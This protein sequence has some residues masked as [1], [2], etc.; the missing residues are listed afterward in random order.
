MMG[1][2][3]WA[4]LAM[5]AASRWIRPGLIEILFLL[6]PWVVVPIAV[7][8]VPAVANS[9]LSANIHRTSHSLI[10]PMAALAT[11]SFFLPAGRVAGTLA[12]AWLLV[13]LL[14]AGEGLLRLLQYRQTSFSEFCF[15]AGEMYLLVGGSWLVISRLGIRP[16]GF[17]EPIVLLTAVHFHFAGFL[18]A[19]LAG[20]TY[21]R[22]QTATWLELLRAALI[23]VVAGPAFL[24]VAFLVG[25]KLKILA[26]L[27]IVAGQMGL[28][29]AMLRVGISAGRGAGRWMLGISAACVVLGMALAATWA[30]G[31]Y[32]LH[33]FVNLY[34]MARF[35]GVLNAVG[36]GLCG[37][38]GWAQIL[39]TDK[40]SREDRT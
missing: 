39:R 5:A 7:N 8:L 18:S 17:D 19:V 27:L 14:L 13:C 35:H 23:A 29:A 40:S 3:I 30:A 24:G 2:A 32:P 31:E 25:P 11:A 22:S 10:L 37:V 38:L 21:E 9:R 26:A 16:V 15:A 36:F 33:P 12:G 1:A 20:L 28:A 6:G 4:G 34:Q